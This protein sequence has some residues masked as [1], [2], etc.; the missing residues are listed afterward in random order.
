MLFSRKYCV[1]ESF[2]IAAE[3]EKKE[4]RER[5]REK[6]DEVK[7][8]QENANW[9]ARIPSTVLKEERAERNFSTSFIFWYFG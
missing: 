8:K 6:T 5:E 9:V 3:E 7:K 1:A 4:R 2:L